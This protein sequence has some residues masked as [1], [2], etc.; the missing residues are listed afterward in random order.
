MRGELI[1]KSLKLSFIC[2]GFRYVLMFSIVSS[3]YMYLFKYQDIYIAVS[4]LL[5]IVLIAS[6]LSDKKSLS[7][8]ENTLII[9]GIKRT[10][11]RRYVMFF[12]LP[13]YILLIIPTLIYIPNILLPMLIIFILLLML[14]I[15]STLLTNKR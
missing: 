2:L 6:F 15:T 14:Y 10:E 1:L 4:S 5:L 11:L 7:Q 12:G 9:I 3:I 8:F 13:R